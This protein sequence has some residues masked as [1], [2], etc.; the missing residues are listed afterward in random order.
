MLNPFRK[1][2]RPDDSYA[3]ADHESKA[4]ENAD[5]LIL[6]EKIENRDDFPK[7]KKMAEEIEE[8]P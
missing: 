7:I 1:K 8:G 5:D 4:P 6:R 3:R 2:P